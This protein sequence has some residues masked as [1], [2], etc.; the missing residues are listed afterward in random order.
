M[1]SIFE[2]L[3]NER[4]VRPSIS[5]RIDPEQDPNGIHEPWPSVGNSVLLHVFKM[6]AHISDGQG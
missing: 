6:S 4:D 2:L 3:N 1:E 5:Y